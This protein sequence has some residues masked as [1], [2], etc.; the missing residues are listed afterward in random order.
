MKGGGAAHGGEARAVR[1][2]FARQPHR[3]HLV[4]AVAGERHVPHALHVQPYVGRL[5][6]RGAAVARQR[7]AARGHVLQKVVAHVEQQLLNLGR[8]LCVG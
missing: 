1:L 8:D 3:L 4:R 2:G 6:H 5:E 7:G